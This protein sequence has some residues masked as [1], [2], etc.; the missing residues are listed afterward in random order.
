MTLGQTATVGT[1][2]QWN[3]NVTR[4]PPTEMSEYSQLSKGAENQIVATHH[5]GDLHVMIVDDNSQLIGGCAIPVGD[6]KVS[7]LFR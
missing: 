2:H 5:F 1:N 7:A 3:M 6:G 4:W